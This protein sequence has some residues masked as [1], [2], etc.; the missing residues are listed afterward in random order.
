MW[1]RVHQLFTRSTVIDLQGGDCRLAKTQAARA[2]S[3]T[4]S[5]GDGE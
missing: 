2:T 1:S 5:K 3:Q 4:S